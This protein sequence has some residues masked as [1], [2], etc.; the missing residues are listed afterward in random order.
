M[1]L[2]LNCPGHCLHSMTIASIKE[3][4]NALNQHS[5]QE[6]SDICIRLAKYK[7]ENKELLHYLLFESRQETHYVESIK[8]KLAELFAGINN[9]NAY[10]VK[11]S[12]RKIIR[13]ANR[14]ARYSNDECTA[15]ELWIYVAGKSQVLIKPIGNSASLQ[16]I[17]ASLVEKIKKAIINLHP[18][19]QYDYHQ[20]LKY[21]GLDKT[22]LE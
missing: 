22:L 12:L 1:D 19:L 8:A 7:L 17:V 11:K 2:G 18:D 14:Y 21:L 5:A 15:I 20:K 3:I 4:K 9:S 10:F 13:T 6:L 16:K